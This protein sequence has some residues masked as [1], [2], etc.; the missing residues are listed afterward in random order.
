MDPGVRILGGHGK[1]RLRLTLGETWRAVIDLSDLGKVGKAGLAQRH[2]L[3]LEYAGDLL[4]RH[5][6][7]R[8]GIFNGPSMTNALP[9]QFNR[10][11]DSQLSAASPEGI[12][13][14][15]CGEKEANNEQLKQLPVPCSHLHR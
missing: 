4:R 5:D 11:R 10:S 6:E 1:H 12:D 9:A 7:W 8:F 14:Y 15:T 13:E 2:H 3:V